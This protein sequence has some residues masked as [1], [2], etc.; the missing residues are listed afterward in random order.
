MIVL[1]IHRNRK[2]YNFLSKISERLFLTFLSEYIIFSIPFLTMLLITGQYS[3]FV[4]TIIALT[5]ISFLVPKSGSVRV[6]SLVIDHIP[7]R[8][9][10]WQSGFR[11]NMIPI[12]IFYAIGLFGIYRIWFS[13][14]SVFFLTLIV[15]SFYSECEPRK[16][17]EAQE[18]NAS[19]FIREKI[20]SHIK[21]MIV[22]ILP[23]FIISLIHF[24]YRMYISISFLVVINLL[25]GAI[26][27]KYAYYNP[28]ITSG[29]HQFIG[30]IA[31]LVSVILPVSVIFLFANMML[32]QKSISHL[33]QYLNGYN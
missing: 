21:A 30:S 4:I 22:F 13:A 18:L 15:C 23:V 20:I 3:H 27:L 1:V 33:N 29:A 17:L 26:L 10:E 31:I 24:E 12:I 9:F 25:I 32:Y 16:I 28:G 2:D 11:R 8:L 5:G 6:Y 14:I 19:M 7:D